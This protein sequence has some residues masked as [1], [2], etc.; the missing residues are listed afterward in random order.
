MPEPNAFL[1]RAWADDPLMSMSL[2]P[3]KKTQSDQSKPG[4]DTSHPSHP[5]L[6]VQLKVED[7]VKPVQ[8][9]TIPASPLEQE[10]SDS[11]LPSSLVDEI[12]VRSSSLDFYQLVREI[13]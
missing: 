11:E 2:V 9:V 5:S 12:E 3:P 10:V 7:I 13:Y 6:Q 1:L 4:I 8:V